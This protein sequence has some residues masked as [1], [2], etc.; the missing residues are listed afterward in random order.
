MK[1]IYV[2]RRSP[3][4]WIRYYDVFEQ[5]PKKRSKSVNT[6]IE[7]S[8]ADR[9][10][11][12]SGKKVAGNA[13]VLRLA[14]EFIRELAKK[15]LEERAQVK[16]KKRIKL[17][18]GLSEFLKDRSIPGTDRY[19]RAKTI[20]IYKQSV[21]HFIKAANDKYLDEYGITEY[22]DLLFYYEELELTQNSR[23]IYTRSLHTLWN[24]F[25]SKQYVL[26]NIIEPLSGEEKDPDPIPLQ[27]METIL[28]YLRAD[29]EYPYH[30]HLI[31]FMFL[32]GCRPSSAVVQLKEEINFK[33]K[34][35]SIHNVKAGGKQ[36]SKKTHY[37]FPLYNELY[38]LLTEQMG[39]K[40]GEMG[41]LFPQFKY[42]ETSYTESLKFWNRKINSLYRTHQISR[43]YILKQIR[44]TS[45]FYFINEMKLSIYTVQKLLD[46][47]TVKVT[48]KHYAKLNMSQTKS[49][50]DD[51]KGLDCFIPS[52]EEQREDIYSSV[53]IL[54]PKKKKSKKKIVAQKEFTLE[55]KEIEL[56]E[57]PL[58]LTNGNIKDKL[59]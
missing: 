23:A 43:Q 39:V 57:K 40:P 4:Y 28:F 1:G 51:M 52:E 34:E 11:I 55:V 10:R 45:A 26:R 20:L 8:N 47:S 12:L 58:T 15:K 21:K 38:N 32:T 35:I 17:S 53:N 42:S 36:S 7:I 5:D 13:E 19:L 2:Q 30:F 16:L 33:R 50:L 59:V 24:Y 44:P 27:D 14:G 56:K 6:K 29:K 31:Y 46:H 41:R 54:K 37:A 48:E 49:E 3:F 18:Q 9:K 25:L 22:N